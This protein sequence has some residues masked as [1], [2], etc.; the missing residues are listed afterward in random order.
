MPASRSKHC[1]ALVSPPVRSAFGSA[2]SAAASARRRH[3][4]YGT[5]VLLD[6]GETRRHAGLAEVFL[7][8]DVAGDLAPLGRHLE[9]S[10]E[11]TTEPSGLRIS[12]ETERKCDG[13]V[14]VP[15]FRGETTRDLH[16]FPR[17]YIC[18][19]N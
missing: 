19:G 10:A 6:R 5:P 11:K 17:H 12:L 3:S 9:F 18:G 2:A 13:L 16:R 4:H 14:G 15:P 7:G 1:L 8:E